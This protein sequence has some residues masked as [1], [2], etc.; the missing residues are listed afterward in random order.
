MQGPRQQVRVQQRWGKAGWGHR[1]PTAAW[2]LRPRRQSL[3][4]LL[5]AAAVAAASPSPVGFARWQFCIPPCPNHPSLLIAAGHHHQRRPGQ[6]A[7]GCRRPG[8]VGRTRPPRRRC[9]L[10]RAGSWIL[11]SRTPRSEGHPLRLRRL[12]QGGWEAVANG[13]GQGGVWSAGDARNTSVIDD[14][15]SEEARH[16]NNAN[17]PAAAAA[18]SSSLT[19]GAYERAPA[20]SASDTNPSRKCRS[21]GTSRREKMQGERCKRVREKGQGRR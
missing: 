2:Q 4:L 7:V 12:L 15:Q 17:P 5:A 16:Y 1:G 19:G 11:A 10:C 14:A 20:D 21:E 6:R 18:A 8:F 3:A 13:V 9:P